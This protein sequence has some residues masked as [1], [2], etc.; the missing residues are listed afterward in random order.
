MKINAPSDTTGVYASGWY[1]GKRL[2]RIRVLL[3]FGLRFEF[4][5]NIVFI[6]QE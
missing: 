1:S 6:Q 4:G 3:V 2:L 5:D